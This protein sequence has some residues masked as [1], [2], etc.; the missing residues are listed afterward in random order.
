MQASAKHTA[1]MEYDNALRRGKREYSALTSR[2][3]RGT[4][5]VLDELTQESRIMAYVKQL[6][7]EISMNR[8]AGTYTSARARSF[9]A[10]FMPL[11]DSGT[12][13][14][15]KWISLCSAHMTEGLRDPIQVYEYMWNYYVIEGNKRVSVLKYFGVPSVRAEITRMI[16]QMDPEDPETATYYAFLRYDRKGKFK[17]IHLSSAER[18]ETLEKVE[19]VL[20]E[21]VEPKDREINFNSMYLRFEGAYAAAGSTLSLGDAFLEYLKVFGLILT[22]PSSL[23]TERIHDLKPQLELTSSPPKE[24]NLLLEVQP[25]VQQQSLISRLFSGRKTAEIIFAYEN[26]RT[27]HN[28]IGAHE[29]GRLEMQEILGDEVSSSS[30]DGLTPDNSYELISEHA[31]GKDLLIVTSARLAPAALRFSLENPDCITLIYSRA[32]Q[33]SRL[34]TYYGRYYEPVFLCGITAGLAT[35]AGKVAYITPHLK[36]GRHTSDINAFALGVKSVRPDA[37]VYL[38]MKNVSPFDPGSCELG[39]RQSVELGC[40]I[41]LTPDYPG[42][43]MDAAPEGSFSFL[44]RLHGLGQPSE[45]LASPTW[46]WGRYYTEIARSYLNNSL[47]FLRIIDKREEPSVTGF[48]WGMASGALEFRSVKFLHPMADNLLQYLRSNIQLGRFKPFR[49]PIFDKNGIE[50]VPEFSTLRPYDILYME[51]LAD[52]I[53]IISD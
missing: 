17:N 16:P 9:S 10:G 52:F 22:E 6:T 49:G 40:D 37:H 33:D 47:E 41:A 50:R 20:L 31:K 36:G 39:I 51:W 38:M 53:H 27:E 24:P 29:K 42:L 19:K 7:R 4:L 32:R 21:Q 26:G 28:W 13:F 8:I 48:W 30:L 25:D 18:Y 23:L 11:Y 44:L 1:R 34:N 5:L 15:G 45:Y 3:E 43:S 46:N 2:G 12:E 35:K 14:A